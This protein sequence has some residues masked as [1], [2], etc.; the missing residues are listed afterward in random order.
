[1]PPERATQL[2][3]GHGVVL[4]EIP[5]PSAAADAGLRVGDIVLRI[6]QVQIRTSSQ[7]AAAMKA[8]SGDVIPVLIRRAGYDF[9]AA[10]RRH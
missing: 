4:S 1:M 3:G 8:Y 2:P 9:W 5:A 10:L 6:G 7:V